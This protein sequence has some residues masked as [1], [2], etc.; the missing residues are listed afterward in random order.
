[1]GSLVERILNDN[2]IINL[3]TSRN[4]KPDKPKG[5]LVNTP[6]YKAPAVYFQDLAR[7]TY[8]IVKGYKGKANDHELGKQNDVAL[9]LGVLATAIY[10]MTVRPSRMPKMM[11]FIGGGSF[12]AAMALWP[13]LAIALPIKLRTGVDIQQKYVDSY[14]RKKGFYQDSQYLP[15]DLYSKEQINKMG[16]KMG[17]P[18]D[19]PNR[20][21]VIK[22]KA[23]MLS[24]QGNTLHMATAGFA[25]PIAAGLACNAMDPYIDK[26]K[27]DHLLRKTQMMM[28]SQNMYGS[29]NAAPKNVQKAFDAFITQKM[30]SRI[31]TNKELIDIMNRTKN[32]SPEMA[33]KLG[34]DLDS[35][36]SNVKNEIKP[37]FADRLYYKFIEP[38]TK[39]G[40]KKD[41]VR[42]VFKDKDLYGSQ[43]GFISRYIKANASSKA[44]T[45]EEAAKEILDG[46]VD[47]KAP[48]EKAL[49]LK[50]NIGNDAV[51]SVVKA[52]NRKI[53]DENTAVHLR[54]VFTVMSNFFRR[55]DML[56]KWEQARF[57]DDADSMGALSWKRV[58]NEILSA[59]GFNQKEL[60]TLSSNG[61]KSCELLEA[62][63]EEI[64]KD[65]KRYRK[66]MTKIAE[67]AA[68]FDPVASE[69]ARQ[70][71]RAYVDELCDPIQAVLKKLGFTKTSEYIGGRPFIKKADGSI[72]NFNEAQH[73]SLR[74]L[75]KSICDE[76]SMSIRSSFYRFIQA[77]DLHRRLQ[78]GTFKGEFLEVVKNMGDKTPNYADVV[79]LAK[80]TILS[81]ESADFETKLGVEGAR[82]TYETVIRLLYGALPDDFSKKAMADLSTDVLTRKPILEAAGGTLEQTYRAAVNSGLDKIN[83]NQYRTGMSTDTIQAL[84]DVSVK[85]GKN[86][87]AAVDLVDNIKG[88]F[89]TF[90]RDAA[91]KYNPIYR[92]CVVPN[93][94][95]SGAISDLP[96]NMLSK[97]VGASPKALVK[98]A[99]QSASNSAKWLKIFGV[100]GAVLFAGTVLSTLFFG[101]LPLKEMYMKDGNKQ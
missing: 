63:M 13:K 80:E 53:L 30:G 45:L 8:G 89:Q 42:K 92:D 82:R 81:G 54:K 33:E 44:E 72:K 38:L 37:D 91:N 19:V 15:W 12:L 49:L 11:E 60:K 17:V 83:L 71:Y 43:E 84:Y 1:M 97:L 90:I 48:A 74:F 32:I 55:E 67:K 101:H 68:E 62:R 24:V 95:I 36:L 18:N 28:D 51:K 86:G 14:G 76:H 77:F 2:R 39:A 34:K 57:A 20:D 35:L 58:S 56:T 52:H 25:T 88:Y 16:D 41:D 59:M 5:H 98:K 69:S 40:I 64:A 96:G 23:R 10:L 70:Q 50:T 22:E 21:E 47:S 61:P 79:K 75:K 85:S 73:G 66:V 7:D 26:M 99:A 27:Q 78:D 100:S 4:V 9:K 29:S 65:P 3:D 94:D 46:L 87:A 6:L 93:H 31:E